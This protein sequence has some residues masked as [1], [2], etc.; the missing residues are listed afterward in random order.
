[1]LHQRL[2]NSQAFAVFCTDA[3]SST[4]YATEEILLV[5]LGV[6]LFVPWI[7]IPI[8]GVITALIFL[9]AISYRQVVYKYSNG[10]GVYGVAKENL[11]E[12]F[13]LIGA[14]SLMIDYVLTPAVSIAAGIAALTS[15][16]PALSE[17]RVA[18]GLF[19]MTVLTIGN[20][21]G[22]KESGRIF[23]IPTYF[24]LATFAG[25]F[26]YGGIKIAMGTFPVAAPP[27]F[28]ASSGSVIG[29]ALVLRAFS[30]GCTALTG[31]EAISNGV[32]A[33]KPPESRH[34]AQV[35]ILMAGVLGTIFFGLTYFSFYG[36]IIPTESETVVSQIAKAIFDTS[37]FY[38]LV[39]A[40][41]MAV[42]L[43]AAN[44]PFADFPRVASRLAHDGYLPH[45]FMNLGSK[46]VYH[47][48]ITF[49]SVSASMLLVLFGGDVHALIPLYAV[50]VF[51]G[52]S[53]TQLGMVVNWK[54]E[55]ML[56]YAGSIAL[57]AVGCLATS[58]VLCIVFYAKFWH[59]AA[60]LL[61][62]VFFIVLG[63]RNIKS[64][65]DMMDRKL[66]IEGNGRHK[67]HTNKTII[68]FIS[69]LNVAAL[70]GLETAQS[71]KPKHIFALH[72]SVDEE[73][74]KMLEAKWREYK[75]QGLIPAH[76]K[77]D[78]VFS[79][80]RDITGTTLEYSKKIQGLWTD[81]ALVIAVVEII[82]PKKRHQVLYG[83]TAK[84]LKAAIKNDPKL[85]AE[86]LEVTYK[87]HDD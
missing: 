26:I 48:G 13:A 83:Q 87:V 42:L 2:P 3:L 50:G 14:A 21:R 55:G 40:A 34:A 70:V 5:F 63:M 6:K 77:L 25:M 52:F 9:V 68:V 32:Q 16:I 64:H 86:I 58:I 72:V 45:Q 10:A 49:L 28:A 11:G 61:P 65:F 7:S 81:D 85:E 31:I 29:F 71:H 78:V 36:N 20:L 73:N 19:V 76:I 75:K 82:P 17:H 30:S 33:F 15:A 22:V 37:I 84:L 27:D 35:L 56:Q 24:F 41:T 66:K 23:S 51:L 4:A 47:F 1:M 18:L 74:G 38:Y 57:N 67:I 43:L 69:K 60:L 59:G 39:Q 80:T 54:R 8:A 46:G 44:T 12:L 62:A 79:E 53:I